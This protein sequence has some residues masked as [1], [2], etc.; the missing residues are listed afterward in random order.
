MSDGGFLGGSSA[1]QMPKV[2]EVPETNAEVSGTEAESGARKQMESEQQK[3]A[4]LEQAQEPAPTTTVV[5]GAN[6][7]AAAQIAE[8]TPKDEITVEVEK[9]LEYGLGDYIPDMPEEARQRFL[10]KGGEVAA[11][12]STMVHTLNVQVTLVVT[13]I[14]EWLLTIPGVNRYYIE[15]ESKI[16]TD[17]IV[18]LANVRRNEQAGVI[19]KA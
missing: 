7:Q 13:L 3:N 11:Q 18:E 17:Q 19:P 14:K 1:E 8:E 9:I 4:F 12:L 2:V 5:P 15:Q 16:K 10:K 6:Q